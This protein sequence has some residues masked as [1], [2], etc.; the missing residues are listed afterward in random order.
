MRK[1][2]ERQTPVADLGAAGDETLECDADYP[3]DIPHEPGQ[4]ASIEQSRA[5]RL[6][7]FR[8]RFHQSSLPVRRIS[9]TKG[10]SF[11]SSEVG[12]AWGS[13]STPRYLRAVLQSRDKISK[14]GLFSKSREKKH[15]S[16]SLSSVGGFLWHRSRIN[17]RGQSAWRF[18]RLPHSR[19]RLD[20]W[21]EHQ[22]PREFLLC[23]Y[24]HGF[25]SLLLHAGAGFPLKVSIQY[26]DIERAQIT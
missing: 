17:K 23:L 24:Q 10:L 19:S 18:S 26:I 8:L 14:N 12:I 6:S 1:R 9:F 4:P 22:E 5:G 2:R 15:R 13:M 7:P 16:M 25:R 3:D 21:F 20:L 11:S